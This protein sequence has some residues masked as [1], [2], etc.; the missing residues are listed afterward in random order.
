MVCFCERVNNIALQGFSRL[1]LFYILY[2][3]IINE[4]VTFSQT[5]TQKHICNMNNTIYER[6][7]Y[8]YLL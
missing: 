8:T 2:N 3:V 1:E 7:Y 4:V 5:R 6:Q